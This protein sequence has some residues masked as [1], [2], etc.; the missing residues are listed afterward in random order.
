[1]R[2]FL[3]NLFATQ[4][5]LGGTYGS[6]GPL[7][8]LSI[9]IQF[10]LVYP[11]LFHALKKWGWKTVF[12]FIAM[13]NVTSYFLLE[14]NGI[15]FFTSYYVTWCIGA[16]IAEVRLKK[17]TENHSRF[18]LVVALIFLG[19]GCLIFGHVKYFSFQI[20]ALAFALFLW[21]VLDYDPGGIF[22]ARV[23]KTAGDFSYS[24]Y[25]VHLP[26]FLLLMSFFFHS[27][28][29]TNIYVSFVLMLALLPFAYL[30]YYLV[31]RPSLNL[32]RTI[33][34]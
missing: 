13:V 3:V 32:L 6:N 7:W 2:S 26:F 5:V 31:E 14:R 18:F 27:E 34:R 28:K 17:N 33:K 9:E 29:Q 8:T 22:W 15:T 12:I 19:V 25:I 21:A 16:Y 20:W 11:L 10:Y 23:L 24:I 1:L 30:V 4:G